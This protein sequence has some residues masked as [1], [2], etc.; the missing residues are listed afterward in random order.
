[1]PSTNV[2]RAQI[3]HVCDADWALSGFPHHFLLEFTVLKVKKKRNKGIG[4]ELNVTTLFYISFEPSPQNI[5]KRL[6]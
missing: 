6:L 2:Y 5:L 3:K 1:M 4:A